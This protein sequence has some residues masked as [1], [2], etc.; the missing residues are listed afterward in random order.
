M[1]ESWSKAIKEPGHLLHPHLQRLR[2]PERGP[3]TLHLQ[4]RE[5]GS[6]RIGIFPRQLAHTPDPMQTGQKVFITEQLRPRNDIHPYL[7]A[8]TR[9]DFRRI[10]SACCKIHQ[11]SNGLL[12]NPWAS[13]P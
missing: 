8:L 9:T 4:K 1:D 2:Q 10:L 12:L 6:K 13:M 7:G 11:L 5:D 3:P